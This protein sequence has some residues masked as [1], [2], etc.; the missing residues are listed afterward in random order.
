MQYII[1]LMRLITGNTTMAESDVVNT[2]PRAED[3]VN[4]CAV[5]GCIII[6]GSGVH[7]LYF[8]NKHTMHRSIIERHYGSRC[9]LFL[10]ANY[11][12]LVPPRDRVPVRPLPVPLRP[13]RFLFEIE[14]TS[15]F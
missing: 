15:R 7:N 14:T 3:S 12:S 11:R 6:L 8:K 4:S 1:V 9:M 10:L 13:L 5:Y 2:L